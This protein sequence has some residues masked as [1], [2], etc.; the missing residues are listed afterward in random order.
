MAMAIDRLRHRTSCDECAFITVRDS[1][2][3][4]PDEDLPHIFKRF[5]RGANALGRLNGTGLGLASV[6]CIV[7]LAAGRVPLVAEA[8]RGRNGRRLA[9]RPRRAR[10]EGELTDAPRS[11]PRHPHQTVQDR[12][13]D[14]GPTRTLPVRNDMSTTVIERHTRPRATPHSQSPRPINLGELAARQERARFA[15][16]L[17][18]GVAQT[19]YA[20][21]LVAARALELLE[22]READPLERLLAQVL[23]LADDGQHE[24]RALLANAWSDDPG[25]GGLTQALLGLASA[26]E[27]RHG[28]H[29]RLA[30]GPEPDLSP[31][32]RTTLVRI[33][34][35]ALHNVA[36]HAGARHVDIVLEV[37]AAEVE[38]LIADDGRGFDPAQTRPGH[39][40]MRSMRHRAEEVGGTLDVTSV[41]G[42][43]TRIRVRVPRRRP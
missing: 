28:T 4:I 34:R 20:I 3:G 18:D 1:G 33:T 12:R 13:Q 36:K 11:E 9:G 42:Q 43:G 29:I 31:A 26:H 21:G 39:F 2:I 10:A 17:H 25:P 8:G 27:T 15:R 19:L 37:R 35:E 38:V 24:V 6:A 32:A 23:E 16:E 7:E 22:P 30:L 14:H 5:Y 40:G 41:D